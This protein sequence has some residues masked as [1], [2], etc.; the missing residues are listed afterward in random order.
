MLAREK[1]NVETEGVGRGKD[2]LK[3]RSFHSSGAV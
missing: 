2:G 1:W 3:F